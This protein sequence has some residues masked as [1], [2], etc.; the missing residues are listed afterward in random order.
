MQNLY[1]DIQSSTK[2]K[3]TQMS[4]NSGMNK[5]NYNI[6]TWDMTRQ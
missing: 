2:L 1:A 4:I 3:T 5:Q 6:H